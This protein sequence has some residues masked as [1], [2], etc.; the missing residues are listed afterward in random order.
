LGLTSVAKFLDI[1]TREL[2]KNPDAV[3]IVA[4]VRALKMNGGVA[5]ND[6]SMANT[7]LREGFANLNRHIDNI[8][9]MVCL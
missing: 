3:V 4:T 6:L 1:K 9:V 2:P 7:S 8:K 5:K